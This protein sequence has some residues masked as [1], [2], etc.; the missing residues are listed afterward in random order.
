MPRRIEQ[1]VD[2]GHR[3]LRFTLFHLHDLV[4]SDNLAFLE[5][6]EVETGSSAGCQKRRHA[7]LV[8]ANAD[9]IAGDPGLCNLEQGAPDPIAIADIDAVI[10]QS[11]D[12]E[13][14]AKLSMDKVGP[15]ELFL[16]IPI[17]LNLVDEDRA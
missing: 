2:L 14:L 12:R 17:G 5:D 15:S 3:H 13:V 6:T 7:G 16:P 8:H 9:A 10:R 1:R 4:A 11:T